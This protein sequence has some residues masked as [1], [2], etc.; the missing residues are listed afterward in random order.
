MMKEKMVIINKRNISRLLNLYG[1]IKDVKELSEIVNR[2][3]SAAID[4]IEEGASQQKNEM[5]MAKLEMKYP[6]RSEKDFEEY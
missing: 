4:E 3:L 5:A 2:H 1:E 6:S